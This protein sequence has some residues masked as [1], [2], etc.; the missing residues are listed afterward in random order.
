MTD[1]NDEEIT[2]T[3]ER[4]LAENVRIAPGLASEYRNYVFLPCVFLSVAL[5]GGLRIGLDNGEFLFVRPALICLVFAVLLLTLF[6]RAKLIEIDGWFSEK[7]TALEN[8]S[9]AVLLISLYAASVQ[10][11]NSLIPEGGI[12]F[13]IVSFCIL[14][15]L[16]NNLFAQFDAKRLLQ[17]LGGLFVFAFAFK[18]MILLN[19]ATNQSGSWWGFLTSGNLTAETISSLLAIPPYAGATGYIQFFALGAFLIGLFF[20]K[21]RLSPNPS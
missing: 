14:W 16:W 8:V 13:W 6:V 5:L 1:E 7:F 12:P 11:F 9:G 17:S 4:K 19:L 18:Y 20:L 21:P 2:V 15:T 3:A 10:V